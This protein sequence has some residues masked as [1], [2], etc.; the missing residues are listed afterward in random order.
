MIAIH[1]LGQGETDEDFAWAKRHTWQSWRSRYKNNTEKIDRLIES[2][3]PTMNPKR[4]NR[5]G[6][7]RRANQVYVKEEQ[8]EDEEEE[9]EGNEN[10]AEQEDEGVNGKRGDRSDSDR[11]RSPPRSAKR[12]RSSGST[13]KDDRQ[14]SV[15]DGDEHERGRGGSPAGEPRS[16]PA[17]DGGR[18]SAEPADWDHQY[19]AG[20]F[21][22]PGDPAGGLPTPQR[23]ARFATS[24]PKNVEANSPPALR[25]RR[26]S[27]EA[28]PQQ[29]RPNP[30]GPQGGGLKAAKR[31]ARVAPGFVPPPDT[32]SGDGST[33]DVDVSQ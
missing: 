15:G 20:L 7:D 5:W 27:F 16:P 11:S 8:E 25:D 29:P 31:S 6:E 30:I 24:S 22:N 32:G 1:F 4:K 28:S 13:H 9:G 14:D 23:R 2:Y 21:D 17:S 10:E 26:Y 12:R 33:S 19:N 18:R 3:V